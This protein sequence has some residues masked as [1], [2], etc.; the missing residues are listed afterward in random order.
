MKWSIPERVIEQGRQYVAEKRVLSVNSI[1]DKKIWS[2]EV[3]G[4]DIFHVE[5]DGSTKEDDFCECLYWK[6]HGYCKHTVAV[7]L[8]LRDR[9]ISRVMTAEN[10][11][12]VAS[13]SPNPGQELTEMI[14][15]QYWI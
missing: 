14:D 10:A 2:A 13:D 5:L 3:M 7:E 9:K 4:S 12:K 11:K 6:N 8:E 15:L 1:L